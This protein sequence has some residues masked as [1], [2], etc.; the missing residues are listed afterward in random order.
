M[1][2]TK[3]EIIVKSI[4]NGVEKVDEHTGATCLILVEKENECDFST[5]LLATNT[6]QSYRLMSAAIFQVVERYMLEGMS[7]K[8]VSEFIF[9]AASVAIDNATRSVREKCSGEH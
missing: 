9:N 2:Q 8:D 7:E 6:H 4:V 1:N 5:H 3:C